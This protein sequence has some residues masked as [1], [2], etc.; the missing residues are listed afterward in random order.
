MGAS[1]LDGHGE[2]ELGHGRSVRQPLGHR[3]EGKGTWEAR[4]AHGRRQEGREAQEA[5][6]ASTAAVRGTSGDG[7]R[8]SSECRWRV[9]QA[10]FFT[11]Y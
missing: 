8:G 6:G 1:E 2:R 5:A 4:R 10:Y 9:G 3:R 7:V 11:P